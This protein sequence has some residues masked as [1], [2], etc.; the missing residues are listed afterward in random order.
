MYTNAQL[1]QQNIKKKMD[2]FHKIEQ[3]SD[4]ILYYLL[5]EKKHN[6]YHLRNPMQF[7]LPSKDD[8]KFINRMLF[9]SIKP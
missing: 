1:T 9:R 2:L 7:K 5:P 8:R 3:N 4:H 6:Q